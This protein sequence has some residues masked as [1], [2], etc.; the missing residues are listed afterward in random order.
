M[1][2]WK[3]INVGRARKK[4][5]VKYPVMYSQENEGN[6]VFNCVQRA[7]QNTLEIYPIF[8][9]LLLSGGLDHP[10]LA[11]GAGVVWIVGRIA[12]ALGYYTGKTEK[13]QQGAFAYLGT[14]TL[15]GCTVHTAI[16]M[17]GWCSK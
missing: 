2:V 14:L 6:N 12:Y 7:H 9:F 4:F 3:S 5:N 10:R 16:K 17:L 15:L 13:R 8:L 1:I 11:S